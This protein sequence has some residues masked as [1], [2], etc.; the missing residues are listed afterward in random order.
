[1][2]HHPN[3]AGVLVVALGCENNQ[4]GAFRELVGEVDETRVKFMESQ[5]IQ[6]MRLSM[7]LPFFVK[8]LRLQPMTSVRM[9]L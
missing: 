9:F 8:S 2:V 1:M 6:G 5:K 4:L 3:A 7:G